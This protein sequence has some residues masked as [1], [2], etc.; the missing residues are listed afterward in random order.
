MMRILAALLVLAAPAGAK[1]LRVLTGAGMAV[2][3]RALAADFGAK[4][5]VQV[6]VVSDTAGGVQKRVEA[7]EKYALEIATTT[8]LDA[9]SDK[10]LLALHHHALAQM[11]A[12]IAVK[13]GEPMPDLPDANAFR[14]LLRAARSIAYVDPAQGGITGVFFMAQAD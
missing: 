11:V 4:A 8:V 6:S 3:V 1:E 10:H 12:G 13:A 7:G 5:N 14:D 9:L 2:P